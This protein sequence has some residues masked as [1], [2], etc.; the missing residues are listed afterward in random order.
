MSA[1]Y[2]GIS[3]EQRSCFNLTLTIQKNGSV[4]NLSGV[5]LTGQIRRDFDDELQAVFT[6]EILSIPSGLAKISLN[7]TQTD[8][9]DLA[10]C[11]WDLFA[12]KENECPDRLLYGPVYITKNITQN[13]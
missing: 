1:A 10:P 12:D 6:A 3:I 8:A 11:S 4:Y 13:T 5:S 9:I 2:T 7:G